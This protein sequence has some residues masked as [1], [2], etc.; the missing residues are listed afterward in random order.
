MD[1]RTADARSS[2][3]VVVDS[4]RGDSRGIVEDADS[5]LSIYSRS[6]FEGANKV[7]ESIAG[8]LPALSVAAVVASGSP[9]APARGRGFPASVNTTLT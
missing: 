9:A 3:I 8:T 1:K 4:G 6:P 5:S 7:P 2:G